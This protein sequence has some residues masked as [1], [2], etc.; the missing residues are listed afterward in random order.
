MAIPAFREDGW[1]PTGH[2]QASWE[3]VSRFGGDP[4]SRRSVLT[5]RL[6]E[7]RDALRNLGVTGCLLLDGSFVSAKQ[8]PGDFDVLLIGPCDIQAMKEVTPE[9]SRLLDTERAEKE[10]GYSLFYI[11]SDS[12]ARDLLGTLWDVSKDGIE[13]G[14]VEVQL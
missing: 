2:H 1:L 4:G 8:D 14:V 11:P 7:L 6:V 10:L 5:A 12:P 13:K 3:V 9:L